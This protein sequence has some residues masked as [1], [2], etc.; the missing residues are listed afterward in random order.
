MGS[1]GL[2]GGV[3]ERGAAPSL[4]PHQENLQVLGSGVSRGRSP[5]LWGQ[6]RKEWETRQEP[7]LGSQRTTPSGCS[8]TRGC[9]PLCTCL[10]VLGTEVVPVDGGVCA[11][12]QPV[13]EQWAL[14][15]RL[16][17]QRWTFPSATPSL[18]PEL[19]SAPTTTDLLPRD[20][21]GIFNER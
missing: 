3:G 13:V 19:G 16:A 14:G 8:R 20:L 12:W 21:P 9:V 11:L 7:G 6:L 17:G 4:R 10:G 1:W 2:Q 18:C 15:V 5:R